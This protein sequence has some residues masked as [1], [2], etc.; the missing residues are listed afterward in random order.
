M[1]DTLP[2][3]WE[4]VGRR[5]AG[6]QPPPDLGGS[7]D[8]VGR[9]PAPPDPDITNR[10]TLRGREL[11]AQADADIDYETGAPINIR[12]QV[13]SADNPNEVYK[14]L[15]RRYGR[16]NFGQ[17]RFGQWWVN[18]EV[19][20]P[21]RT[22]PSSGSPGFD[23]EAIG[24]AMPGETK[25]EKRRVA[26]LPKGLA[27]GLKNFLSGMISSP[28]AMAGAAGGAVAGET[29]FPPGGAIPGAA[30]G[31]ALGKGYDLGV[32]WMQGI[33]D[34]S[35]S[36]AAASM[37]HEGA[38]SG[39]FQG[40]GPL[41]KA[42]KRPIQTALQTKLFGT[43]EKVQLPPTRGP[44]GSV[45][46]RTG[47]RPTASATM[48]RDLGQ[49]GAVPPVGVYAPGATALEY[50]RNL[51]DILAGPGGSSAEQR[52]ILYLNTRMRG[53]LQ[54]AGFTDTEIGSMLEL[55]NDTTARL[56]DRT[57]GQTVAT[58][59]NEIHNQLLGAAS[60][61]RQQAE[62]ILN[63][64][65]QT[66]DSM[67]RAPNHLV[68]NIT[69]AIENS[70][71]HFGRHMAGL[72]Q[73]VDRMG[74]NVPLV[75]TAAIQQAA[76]EVVRMMP[77]TMVPPR[78]AEFA[79]GRFTAEARNLDV[80][81]LEHYITFEQAHA[82][83]TAFR[84][85]SEVTDLSGGN[86]SQHF[87]RRVA[88]AANL[89]IE[90]A[91]GI[92]GRR[93]RDELQRVDTLYREGIR[94]YNNRQ[95]N[96]I[97]NEMRS[98][99][100]PEPELAAR[101][102][103]QPDHVNVVRELK[104]IL[105]NHAWHGL[106]QADMRNMI[107]AATIVNKDGRLVLDGKAFFT[108]LNDRNKLLSAVYPPDLLGALRQHG[109]QLAA[110]QGSVDVNALQDATQLTGLLKQ[111]VHVRQAADL[112]AQ[113]SPLGALASADPAK[114]DAALDMITR[115]GRE[116]VTESV[117]DMLGHNSQAW[118]SVQRYALQKLISSSVIQRKSLDKT[119]SGESIDNVLRRLTPRQQELL[120]P[121]GLADDLRILAKEA[122]FLFPGAPGGDVG[123][124]FAAASIKGGLPLSPI[125]LVR[126]GH[127]LISGFIADHPRLLRVLTDVARADPIRAR[128]YMGVLSQLILTRGF[129]RAPRGQPDQSVTN[130]LVQPG[131]LRGF[132][133]RDMP[134]RTS[135]LTDEN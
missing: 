15:E 53:V 6:Q 8:L 50:K 118:K 124:S 68:A 34:R 33:L 27:G 131:S 125:A 115:P 70:R 28:G 91:E 20:V 5:P 21:T 58:R 18:E 109:A 127:M 96:Q 23:P 107:D 59:A 40:A 22:A 35:P 14:A 71:A 60:D 98:G 120:F 114:V 17:D 132:N 26:V 80:G 90:N 130:P 81:E 55:A 30:I 47:V 31:G 48:G 88:R 65:M 24:G 75:P 94:R 104:N 46:P 19:G 119:V 69:D 13:Q 129:A 66:L 85:L 76:Q 39:A 121:D 64:E 112:F 135:P 72:Y 9:R 110:F 103:M 78:L 108:L 37:M 116:A 95:L 97:V 100:N 99:I 67:S 89:A 106:I 84:E 16:G 82:I 1:P 61:S 128:S 92:M 79:A 86:M 11:A 51:R 102:L 7:P 41:L 56:S 43:A 52:N 117:A 42:V 57:A 123:T 32:K 74:G 77:P 133:P 54:A 105:P 4:I 12:A 134:S 63:R 113:R 45:V 44:G 73:N 122:R 87:S 3:G 62:T 126:Y 10:L 93:A 36:Q 2:G 101:I 38:V 49:G 25:V 29:F 111:A 83:R